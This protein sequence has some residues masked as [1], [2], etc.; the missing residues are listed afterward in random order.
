MGTYLNPGNTQFQKAI[1][2]NPYVDKSGLLAEL[3]RII[4]TNDC[5]VC[6]S[7]PRRFGKTM[8]A[9][10]LSAYY[11][12]EHDT[13]GMFAGLE[14]ENHPSFRQHLNK[15]NV[16]FINMVEMI[17]RST[18]REMI[19]RIEKVLSKEFQ[20]AYPDVPMDPDMTFVDYLKSIHQ[21]TGIG[22][23][24]IIDE[25]DCIFRENQNNQKAQKE[26]LEFLRDFLKDKPYISLAYM[27]GILPIKKYGSHSALNMFNE[28]SMT[29]PKQFDRFVGFTADE[30]RGLCDR[31]GMDF[32]EMSAWYDG[33]SFPRVPSVFNPRSV[34]AAL[35]SRSYGNYWTRT[36]T[37]EALKVYIDMDT[38]GLRGDIVRLLAGDKVMIES[39]SFTNDMV[40]FAVKDDVLTLLVHLGYLG[41]LENTNEVFVPNKEIRDEFMTS[42]RMSKWDEVMNAVKI[43]DS[44]LRATWDGDA[45]A[46]AALVEEA[47]QETS[48]LTYNDENALAYTVS[49]AY[50]SARQYY[51]IIR[52]MPS[53]KG[54]ADM[55]FLPVRSHPDK[56]AMVIELKWDKSA[57]GAIKQI[58]DKNYPAA[59][60][61]H[62]GQ[63]LLVGINYDKDTKVHTCE[64]E[65]HTG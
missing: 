6:I 42:I 15:Y 9:N 48:H 20:K 57:Q 31:Y 1:N 23:V 18:V 26:Y 22:M 40:T 29:S 28:F 17:N 3:N 5:F 19:S 44:L 7:R 16:V 25:W 53:G 65:E 46:V 60:K 63:L 14:I 33:Y 27:T 35:S 62:T 54:Y 39:D 45:A 8:A 4:N 12:C 52:E 34:V 50:Y 37:Y 2:N 49:L 24:V 30:V 11:G 51:S 59:L 32:S 21:A 58:K 56:P 41:F 47:H 13:A 64:I 36:E 43:S 55:I 10:M 38:D 61:G